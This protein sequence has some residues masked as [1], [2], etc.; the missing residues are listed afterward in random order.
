MLTFMGKTKVA[1]V[2]KLL[3][4]TET[5]RVMQNNPVNLESRTFRSPER[6]G[7]SGMH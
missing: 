4:L 3:T 2:R 5:A 7:K 1:K 6:K